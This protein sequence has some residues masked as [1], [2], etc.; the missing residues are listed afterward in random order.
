MLGRQSYMI[1]A[2]PRTGSYLLCHLLEET[3]VAGRPNEYFNESFQ[4]NWA[5][6]WNAT[7]LDQYVRQVAAL[8][9]TPNGVLGLKIH[10]M[11][12]DGLCRQI[13]G[14]RRVPF[15]ERP[16][17]LDRYFPGL[18]YVRLSRR[19]RLRQAISYA[20][21][22]QTGAWWDSDRPP[23]P[24]AEVKPERLRFD[25]QL[26]DRAIAWLAAMDQRWNNY[27]GA[28]G[29]APLELD[30][31]DLIDDPS[32]VVASVLKVLGVSADR[33]RFRGPTSFRRQADEKT[34]EWAIRFQR[35]RSGQPSPVPT[36]RPMASGPV[37]PLRFREWIWSNSHG[38]TGS[39][40]RIADKESG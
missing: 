23:G 11:Q 10:T 26:I 39:Q 32:H 7:S 31:E 34:E 2:V 30:Y 1:C 3:G 6:A 17:L 21:A 15:V 16:A 19:D 29:T 9:T 37:A 24:T 5:A 13:A 33:A 22:V 12:F 36:M 25:Y 4:T 18:T 28:I 40:I 20:R 14:R 35:I 8:G 38:R 27:F